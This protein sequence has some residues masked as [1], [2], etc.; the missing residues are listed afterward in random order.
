MN[1]FLFT[2]EFII[3]SYSVGTYAY[4]APRLRGA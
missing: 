1:G 2:F 4:Y 3:V